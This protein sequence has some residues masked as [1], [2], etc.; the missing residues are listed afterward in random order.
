MTPGN[1]RIL[2]LLEGKEEGR[3]IRSDR[4]MTIPEAAKPEEQNPAYEGRPTFSSGGLQ[5]ALGS[6]EG[7]GCQGCGA[8]EPAREMRCVTETQS[9]G[10]FFDGWR[11]LLEG[12]LREIQSSPILPSL[13]G[14][15]EP[16][17]EQVSC[18]QLSKA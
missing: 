9:E 16:G 8:L 3:V 12:G 4:Q 10:D 7:R 1:S 14:E 6:A 13:R 18:T 5:N 11:V 15:T 17:A 2:N